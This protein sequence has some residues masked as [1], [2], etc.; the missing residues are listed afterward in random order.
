MG[1]PTGSLKGTTSGIVLVMVALQSRKQLDP[2]CNPQYALEERL[3]KISRQAKSQN[4]D[5]ATAGGIATH[6]PTS[7]L[8]K[9]KSKPQGRTTH[10]GMNVGV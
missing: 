4:S 2:E 9:Y 5:L 8:C 6:C 3:L 1:A 10:V 7:P